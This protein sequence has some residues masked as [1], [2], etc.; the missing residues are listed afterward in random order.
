MSN[1]K[2]KDLACV[3]QI[4]DSQCGDKSDSVKGGNHDSGNDKTNGPPPRVVSRSKP[5]MV[6]IAGALV[7]IG[8]LAT[9][10]PW[11]GNDQNILEPVHLINTAC[12][13]VDDLESGIEDLTRY[14]LPPPY[15]PPY[16]ICVCRR[17]SL[18]GRSREVE[19]YKHGFEECNEDVIKLCEAELFEKNQVAFTCGIRTQLVLP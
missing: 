6:F 17:L 10:P 4:N 7:Y 8:A 18:E 14:T 12:D 5:W 19:C 9:T 11:S 2:K 1:D 13:C 15:D 3:S 16:A